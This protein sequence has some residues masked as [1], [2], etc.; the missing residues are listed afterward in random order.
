VQ[1]LVEQRLREEAHIMPCREH[2]RL[3]GDSAH[4]TRSG[5]MHCSTQQMIEIRIG[6]RCALVVMLRGSDVWNPLLSV[7]QRRCAGLHH[8]FAKCFAMMV[9]AEGHKCDALATFLA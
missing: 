8:G 7:P 6:R 2:A 9:C 1:E 3:P 4:A 5:I